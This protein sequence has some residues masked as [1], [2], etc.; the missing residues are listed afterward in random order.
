VVI[1]TARGI[2]NVLNADI[3]L[4][5]SGIAGPGGGT[6]EKPVGLTCFGVSIPGHE[7]AWTYIWQG[8]RVENKEHSAEKAL[9]L[10]IDFLKEFD[11]GKS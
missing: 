3:G 5:V 7:Q 9:L 4:A 10:L 8:S 6:P 2:R 1:E 11:N